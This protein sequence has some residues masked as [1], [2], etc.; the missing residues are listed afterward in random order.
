MGTELNSLEKLAEYADEAELQNEF[1]QAKNL[2]KES[3]IQYLKDTTGVSV[4]ANAIFDIQIKRI[5]EYKRQLLNI[6][7]IVYRYKMIKQSTD[8][9]RSL[10][11]PKACI[12][13]G[14]A[15]ITYY[16]AK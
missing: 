4:T 2:N 14:K 3:S 10:L 11:V 16:Q 7:G 1:H 5:H 13:G 15:F 6:M 12:F 9:E 8:E